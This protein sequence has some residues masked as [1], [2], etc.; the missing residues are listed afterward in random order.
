MK[1][2]WIASCPSVCF[3]PEPITIAL[4]ISR[5]P[6]INFTIA[7]SRRIIWKPV[8]R[9]TGK[10]YG[11]KV[12]IFAA[13]SCVP[14]CLQ[15]SSSYAVIRLALHPISSHLFHSS[16]LSN[17]FLIPFLL[18]YFFQPAITAL[19]QHPAVC[20]TATPSPHQVIGIWTMCHWMYS[21]VVD[22]RCYASLFLA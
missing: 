11:H 3:I 12:N 5:M 15:I 9:W 20:K 10:G 2:L 6:T 14:R 1:W 19:K 8:L 7:T 18:P 16:Q 17:P 22:C 4:K 21:R 13:H